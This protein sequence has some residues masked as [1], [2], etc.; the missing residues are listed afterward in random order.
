MTRLPALDGSLEA[1]SIS[2]LRD[3]NNRGQIVGQS[4]GASPRRRRRSRAALWQDGQPI[5]L[6]SDGMPDAEVAEHV[7]ERG[8]VLV[9]SYEMPYL[10][11]DGEATPSLSPT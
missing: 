3:I 1:P 11:T 5:E 10:W 2:Y 7:N 6:P 8:Q 9:N 4:I